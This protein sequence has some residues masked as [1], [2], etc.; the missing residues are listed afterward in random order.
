[1][2]QKRSGGEERV[3]AAIFIHSGQGALI[4]KIQ[5]VKPKKSVQSFF[6]YLC[7]QKFKTIIK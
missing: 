1:M 6:F 5:K 7:R 4:F 2:P 3:K